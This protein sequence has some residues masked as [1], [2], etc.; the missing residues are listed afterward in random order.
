MHAAMR[1]AAQAGVDKNSFT[2]LGAISKGISTGHVNWV[3]ASAIRDHCE[4][5]AEI[6]TTGITYMSGNSGGG[7]YALASSVKS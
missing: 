5:D 6:T 1:K 3:D 4:E 2:G 7:T